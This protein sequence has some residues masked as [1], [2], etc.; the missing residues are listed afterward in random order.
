M[1]DQVDQHYKGLTYPWGYNQHSGEGEPFKVAEGVW[2]VRFPMPMSL[3]HINIWLLEDGDGWTIVDTCLRTKDAK[4]IWESLFSGFMQGKPVKRVICTH[5]HPDHMGLASWICERFGCELLMT[6]EE[7]LINHFLTSYTG[8][9][10]PEVG[11][12][13]YKRCGF[14]E[15]QLENYKKRFGGFGSM[16]YRLPDSYTQITDRQTLTIGD[17]YWQVI[18]GKG[19][20]PEHACLYCP[21]LKVLIAGDQVLPRITSNVSV[22]PT[23]PDGNP[24][25]DW[26]DSCARLKKIL[27]PDLL[28]LPS[29]QSP[30]TGLHTRL[31]Q[32]I[33]FHRSLLQRILD[34]LKSPQRAIDLYG[35]MFGREINA[36]EYLMAAGETI[37]HLHLL[38]ATGNI[39][40]SLDAE[41]VYWYEQNPDSQL[42]K[43]DE[44]AIPHPV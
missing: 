35:V 6:R 24:L 8:Q 36:S 13:F 3:D 20:S 37:A 17:N 28:V 22:F 38:L 12:R 26:L 11:I 19:H 21:A 31:S 10:A 41:G 14:S 27:P 40:R 5:M 29:H 7:Y 25:T 34:T 44:D 16:I 2:W 1:L 23:E 30:F 4:A 43:Q 18:I 15:D 32:L 9:E 42:H 39:T 33:D